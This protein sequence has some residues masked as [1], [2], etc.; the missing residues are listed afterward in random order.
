MVKVAVGIIQLG[1]QVLVCQRKKNARY[2]LQWEFPG[3]KLENG[4]LPEQCLQRELREE[5]SIEATIGAE[6]HHQSWTYPDAGSF[7]VSY[8]LVSSYSGFIKNNVFEHIRWIP[9]SELGAI[10][11]LEGNKEVVALLKT[12]SAS[13]LSGGLNNA[14]GQNNHSKPA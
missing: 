13:P 8:Y 9:V 4:E 2:G 5:L 1:S 3:G 6:I 7:E 12:S 10:A 14:H 11:M